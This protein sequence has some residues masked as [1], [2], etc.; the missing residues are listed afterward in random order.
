MIC[1]ISNDNKRYSKLKY[2][3]WAKKV[4]GTFLSHGLL[5]GSEDAKEADRHF[6]AST[7][8]RATHSF[9]FTHRSYCV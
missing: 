9:D 3:A 4:H 2:R 5:S 8:T 6:L 7:G 1:T